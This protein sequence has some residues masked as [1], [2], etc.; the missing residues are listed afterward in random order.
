MPTRRK[1]T[2]R[3]SDKPTV[4]Q[5]RDFADKL[6][7]KRRMHERM[8]ELIGRLVLNAAL[9][10]EGAA[11]VDNE[12]RRSWGLAHWRA[13]GWPDIGLRG[14]INE[15]LRVLDEAASEADAQ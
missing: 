5:F 1:S 9:A 7:V 14:R 8:N 10:A 15:A 6:Y 4:A 3:Y 2:I 11:D 12:E 13:A